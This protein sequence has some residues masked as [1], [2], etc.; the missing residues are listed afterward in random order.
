MTGIMQ[1]TAPQLHIMFDGRSRDVD[2]NVIDVG[3]LSTDEQV[4]RAAATWMASE[5]AFSEEAQAQLADTYAHKLRSFQV[6]PNRETGDI[7]LAPEATWG[8]M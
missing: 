5:D 8:E 4:R 3:T 1:Q 2:L 7:D 6:I